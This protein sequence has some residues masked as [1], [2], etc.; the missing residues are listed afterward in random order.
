MTSRRT[1][2]AVPGD[3]SAVAFARDRV[4][5]QV[6]AWGVGLDNDRQDAVRLVISELIT[7]AVVHVGGMVSVGLYL[8]DERLLLVV[9]DHSQDLPTLQHPD[10]EQETGR[11]LALVA[12]FADEIGWEPTDT[13]KKV[14][15]KFE[16]P[17]LA[18]TSLSERLRR[19]WR[20]VGHRPHLLSAP[21]GIARMGIR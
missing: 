6:G 1:R 10:D 9:H 20:A 14:W 17:P 2:I 5:A 13:G 11:G 15:A 3:P 8:D 18:K 16:V 4:V 12:E 19:R 21:P 7:N